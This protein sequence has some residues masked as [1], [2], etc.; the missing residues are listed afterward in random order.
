MEPRR[1]RRSHEISQGSGIP[2]DVAWETDPMDS[3]FRDAQ[4]EK[5]YREHLEH[6]DRDAHVVVDGTRY[7]FSEQDLEELAMAARYHW[8]AEGAL[9]SSVYSAAVNIARRR[10][11]PHLNRAQIIALSGAVLR[12]TAERVEESLNWTAG[13]MAMHDGGEP[14]EHHPY[15]PSADP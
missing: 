13:Y 15:P 7:A 11:R 14:E 12:K 5:Q 2:R 6:F 8:F 9:N 4:E 10:F 1:G 3:R